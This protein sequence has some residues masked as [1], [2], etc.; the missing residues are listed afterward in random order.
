MTGSL[1]EH[2]ETGLLTRADAGAIAD[3]MISLLSDSP[4]RERLRRAAVAAVGERTWEASQDRLAAGYRLALDL[5]AP[6]R[7]RSVA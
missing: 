5:R 1:I 3:A 4:L 2:G 7:A 6:G